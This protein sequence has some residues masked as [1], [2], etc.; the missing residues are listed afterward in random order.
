MSKFVKYLIWEISNPKNSKN[1]QF[2]KQ[3]Q[4]FSVFG[5]LMVF[6]IEKN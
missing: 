4:N 6:Q 3:F 2:T 5:I 1:F